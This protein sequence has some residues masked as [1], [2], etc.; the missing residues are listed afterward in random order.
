MNKKRLAIFFIVLI[1]LSILAYYKKEPDFETK[2]VV[3]ESVID[4]DTLTANSNNEAEKIRLKGINTP[5]KNEAGFNEAKNF[6]SLYAGKKLVLEYEKNEERDK[7]GRILAY[8]FL[9]NSLI[10]EEIL[11]QGLAHFFSYAEDKYTKRM[12]KAEK[13]ARDEGRGIWKKSENKCGSCIVL[14]SLDNGAGKDD[15]QAGSESV[16]FKNKCEINCELKG[17]SIKDDATH[18]FIFPNFVLPK[19]KKI[20]IYN[21]KGKN[22]ESEMYFQN[23][24]ECTS[25]WNDDHDSLFFRDEQGGIVIFERY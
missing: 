4:G 8:L 16:V 12:L 7:Y 25:L 15:C 21:G 13:I 11:K 19:D 18:I 3:V 22:T 23:S 1:A 14:E 17:W 9:D 10:N 5:E 6:L 2:N 20:I 24:G